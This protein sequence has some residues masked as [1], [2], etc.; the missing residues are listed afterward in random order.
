MTDI[1][2]WVAFN[3]IPHLGTVRFRQLQE[4]FGSL[5]EAWNAREGQLR[6]AGLDRR[7]VSEIL[8]NRGS[9]SPDHEAELL[10]QAGVRA[11]TWSDEEY[12]D[13]LKEIDD[14][15]PVLYV[16]GEI[17]PD[18]W[19]SIAIVGTRS[20][21][22]YGKQ[23]A[24]TLTRDLVASGIT[25][26]SGL[27]R[28]IDGIAHHEVIQSG[29]RTIAVMA[30]GLD[31]IYPPEHASLAASISRQ[32]ALVS[33]HPLGVKPRSQQFPRRNRIMSGMTLGTLVIEAGEGSGAVRTVQHA[34]E[35]GREVFCVP[36][37]IFS[38]KSKMTNLL[39]Q[40]G[41]KLVLTHEDVLQELNLSSIPQQLAMTS[42]IDLPEGDERSILE[43]VSLEPLHIDEIR[44][45]SQLP[46]ALV[47]STLAM[48]E[49]KGLVRQVGGMN[50]VRA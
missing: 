22:P 39:I 35:Q 10:A 3:R 21:T 46:I 45:R 1:K 25:V 33:E 19:C 11:V 28:G 17:L 41:A 15:P 18:D 23:A 50:Y 43:Q 14:P 24:S 6:A 5:G 38:L 29:G 32:G 42:V 16:K 34:L 49:L 13:R 26:V 40:Q 12:P 9:I 8:S 4:H 36:G 47:S 2:Y 48:M 31:I 27:A 37:S 20:A 44:W 7:A 30:C